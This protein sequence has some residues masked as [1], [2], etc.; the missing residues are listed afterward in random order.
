MVHPTA[1]LAARGITIVLVVLFHAQ[2]IV[3]ADVS[4]FGLYW[5][6]VGV[7]SYVLMPLFFVLAG[8][9][10]SRVSKRDKADMF[11]VG[12]ATTYLYLYWTW[13]VIAFVADGLLDYHTLDTESA[14]FLIS[15]VLPRDTLWFLYALALYVMAARVMI[16]LPRAIQLGIALVLA[17]VPHFFEMGFG[18]AGVFANFFFFLVGLSYK[19]ELSSFLDRD[20]RVGSAVTGVLYVALVVGAVLVGVP[21]APIFDQITGMVGIALFIFISRILVRTALEPS[22][23]ALGRSTLEIY[24]LH[25]TLMEVVWTFLL[26]LLPAQS[27]HVGI[28]A[29]PV[30]GLVGVLGS[31]ALRKALRGTPGL[32]SAPPWAMNLIGNWLAN[33][34]AVTLR[35]LRRLR[36]TVRLPSGSIAAR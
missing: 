22:L 15:L 14:N 7:L 9:S 20:P 18:S 24:L 25:V 11:L 27:A 26:P 21:R 17:A 2:L 12:R 34:L 35:V 19:S 31:L 8:M 3:S 16:R 32:F 4:G 13:T 36:R 30:L 6:L 29:P 33:L 5:R 23:S 1:I 10:M 28:F